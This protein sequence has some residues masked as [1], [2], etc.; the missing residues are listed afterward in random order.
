MQPIDGH[1]GDGR[2]RQRRGTSFYCGTVSD[3]EWFD[4]WNAFMFS[5]VLCSRA[6]CRLTVLFRVNVR[7]QN[8]HG[9][10]MP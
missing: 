10:L 8:G 3:T 4:C 2:R 5:S 6:I 7:E 9:T 1:G